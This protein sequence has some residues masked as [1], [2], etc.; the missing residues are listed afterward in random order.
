MEIIIIS[1]S[2]RDVFK[3]R[4]YILVHVFAKEILKTHVSWEPE[5]LVPRQ[6]WSGC[7]YCDVPLCKK[8]SC[9]KDWHAQKYSLFPF[10]DGILTFAGG[11]RPHCCCQPDRCPAL[12]AWSPRPAARPP[13][14]H[15]PAREPRGLSWSDRWCA[16]RFRVQPLRSRVGRVEG[17]CRGHG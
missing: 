14:Q 9:F 17:V 12:C 6:V 3:Y 16:C 8:G 15:C 5:R 1:F 4:I 7:G 2:I 13:P 10:T 11:F